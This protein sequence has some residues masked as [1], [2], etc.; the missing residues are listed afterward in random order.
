MRRTST[1]KHT[2]TKITICRLT[3]ILKTGQPGES[4]HS[5]SLQL[6]PVNDRVHRFK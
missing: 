2:D 1:E 6:T 4:S 5:V 3:E